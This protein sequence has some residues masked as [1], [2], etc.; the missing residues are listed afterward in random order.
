M[1]ISSLVGVLGFV[2]ICTYCFRRK[3]NDSDVSEEGS[4]AESSPDYIKKKSNSADP[5]RLKIPSREEKARSLP[6]TPGEAVVQE[7]G[8]AKRS[9]N[10]GSF[11]PMKSPPVQ[12]FNIQ[13]PSKGDG[14]LG[15]R[16]GLGSDSSVQSPLLP[17][18]PEL[19][20]DRGEELGTIYF[21]LSY[22]I[23][24]LVLKLSIQKAINLPAKDI[25]GTSDPFVKVMLLPDKKHKLETRVKRKNLNP[26]WNE[27]FTFEGFPHQKLLQRTLYM[28]VLDYDRFSRNDP[29]GEVELPLH[30]VHLQAEPVPFIKKL[31]PCKRAPVSA[32]IEIYFYQIGSVGGY[33]PVSFVVMHSNKKTGP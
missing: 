30:D 23:Y 2:A 12:E 20:A 32:L 5:L 7:P 33:R 14:S 27:V 1:I 28:Q 15:F 21:S 17:P 6:G 11:S 31:K 10:Y 18:E 4:S 29:I 9:V 24:S 16:G 26:V 3:S 19:P 8:W 13:P 22:D 25:S